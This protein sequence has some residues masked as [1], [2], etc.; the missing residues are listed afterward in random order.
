MVL[1]NK[2]ILARK[3]LG[4]VSVLSWLKEDLCKQKGLQGVRKTVKKDA[5]R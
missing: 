2:N 4:D 3:S 1:E 5:G